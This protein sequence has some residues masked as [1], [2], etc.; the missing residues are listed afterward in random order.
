MSARLQF[1]AKIDRKYACAA[2]VMSEIRVDYIKILKYDKSWYYV[3]FNHI[4]TQ[5]YKLV[6]AFWYSTLI[7]APGIG[8]QTFNDFMICTNNVSSILA[9]RLLS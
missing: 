8:C 4:K 3:H 9:T 7:L 1:L 5:K 6:Y 2:H